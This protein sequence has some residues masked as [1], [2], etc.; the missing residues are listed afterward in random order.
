MNDDKRLAAVMNLLANAMTIQ[1]AGMTDMFGN[2]VGGMGEALGSAFGGG[3]EAGPKPGEVGK[4][5][6]LDVSAMTRDLVTHALETIH[7]SMEETVSALLPEQ[8]QGLLKDIRQESYN[9]V[10]EAVK[11]TDF[12]LPR[13]TERL[14]VDDLLRYVQLQDPRL[15]DLLGR[16]QGLPQPEAFGE[17]GTEGGNGRA[18]ETPS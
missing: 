2:L 7:A 16:V 6:S 18:A 17:G 3:D 15:K 11:G 8:K 12:G 4:Q 9:E 14:S 1:M 10:L 5:I 13:L